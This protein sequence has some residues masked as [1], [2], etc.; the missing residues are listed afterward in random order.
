MDQDLLKLA[1]GVCEEFCDTVI[2]DPENGSILLYIPKKYY[3]PVSTRLGRLNF[4]EIF[5]QKRRKYIVSCLQVLVSID[6]EEIEF[7]QEEDID[8][9]DDDD[10]GIL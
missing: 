8:E 2:L 9:E 4:V 3:G 1:Y 5:K 7:I 10:N 6:D